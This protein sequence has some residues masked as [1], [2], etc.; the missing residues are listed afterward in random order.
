MIYSVMLEGAKKRDGVLGISRI[1]KYAGCLLNAFFAAVIGRF[2]ETTFISHHS[3]SFLF[4]LFFFICLL[5]FLFRIKRQFYLFFVI[6]FLVVLFCFLGRALL[7]WPFFETA[8]TSGLVFYLDN[9]EGQQPAQVPVGHANIPVIRNYGLESG[10]QL[11]VADL[12]AANSPFL[13]QEDPGQFWNAVQINLAESPTQ[14]EYNRR[15]NFEH[16]DLSVRESKQLTFV[17]FS[18]IFHNADNPI[19]G[20]NTVNSVKSFYNEYESGNDFWLPTNEEELSFVNRVNNDLIQHGD[21]SEYYQHIL[22]RHGHR[23]Y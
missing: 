9:G 4:F 7:F 8:L 3:L 23:D 17:F 5:I 11:R 13:A 16:M 20:L 1:M 2:L 12:E 15:L 6:Q 21:S 14:V 19:P 18:Q 22:Y 10:L